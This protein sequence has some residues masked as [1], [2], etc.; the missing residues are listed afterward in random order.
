MP[1][2]PPSTPAPP[3]LPLHSPCLTH[4]LATPQTILEQGG[5][6]T[7]L[8][9]TITP[10]PSLMSTVTWSWPNTSL[11]ETL[12]V[13]R[14]SLGPAKEA[15]RSTLSLSTLGHAPHL[16]S[17]DLVSATQTSASFPLILP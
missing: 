1:Q 12:E 2:L 15:T 10:S 5:P 16:I 13:K 7:V 11:I 6:S 9:P 8:I 3:V 17:L 4:H 14:N